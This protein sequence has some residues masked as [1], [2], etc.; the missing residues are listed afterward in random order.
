VRTLL[1]ALR[2]SLLAVSA[3]AA[4]VCVVRGLTPWRAVV[5]VST[6]SVWYALSRRKALSLDRE[7]LG[8]PPR[9][10]GI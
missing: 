3:A 1:W 7:R 5:V 6:G 9:G 2:W 4:L 10:P 8:I